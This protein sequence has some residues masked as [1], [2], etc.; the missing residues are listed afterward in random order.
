MAAVMRHKADP[1][2]R[3][4]LVK[5]DLA[6]MALQVANIT[7]AEVLLEVVLPMVTGAGAVDPVAKRA[8]PLQA[9]AVPQ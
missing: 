7:I 1:I 6:V 5:V 4:N 9:W 2:V 8:A 3:Q